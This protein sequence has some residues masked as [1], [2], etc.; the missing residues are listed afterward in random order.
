MNWS[1]DLKYFLYYFRLEIEDQTQE[2]TAQEVP[3]PVTPSKDRKRKI[4]TDYQ[5]RILEIESEKLQLE[6]Q[7]ID[8]EKKRFEIEK[9][10]FEL[11]MKFFKEHNDL[12]IKK[13]K[14]EI[15]NLQKNFNL[16]LDVMNY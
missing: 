16:D 2:N 11:E 5:S 12:K 8:L 7:K 3:N 6:Q 14:L 15:D 1:T 13:I 9:Q 10:R 4:S